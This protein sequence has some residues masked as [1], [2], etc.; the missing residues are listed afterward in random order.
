MGATA[1][2]T[3]ASRQLHTFVVLVDTTVRQTKFLY[4]SWSTLSCVTTGTQTAMVA[5]ALL[6]SPDTFAQQSTRR[7][8]ITETTRTTGGEAVT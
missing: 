5:N 1:V 7:H 4:G 8:D 2:N 3:R 6:V